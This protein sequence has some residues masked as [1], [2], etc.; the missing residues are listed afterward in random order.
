MCLEDF[1]FFFRLVMIFMKAMTDNLQTK[2]AMASKKTY[3]RF[4][5]VVKLTL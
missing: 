2:A 1:F 4:S 5:I 3:L